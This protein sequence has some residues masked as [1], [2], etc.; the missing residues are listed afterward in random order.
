[1][2]IIKKRIN[3]VFLIGIILLGY[4]LRNHNINTWPRLGATFDEYAWVW[5]G[6]SL[7]KK[8]IGY[9]S[10]NKFYIGYS[11]SRASPSFRSDGGKLCAFKWSRRNVRF[12]YK[13]HS[14][15]SSFF[16]GRQRIAGLFVVERAI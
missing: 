4:F 5:Q 10:K 16:R 2:S 8:K 13:G 11:I 7:I 3:L 15:F 9:L 14:R 6:I 1:M 12:G